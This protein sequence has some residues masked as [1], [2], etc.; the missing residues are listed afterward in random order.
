MQRRLKHICAVA[1]A[2]IGILTGGGN[3]QT[4]SRG[5]RL[6]TADDSNTQFGRAS[7]LR[8]RER[9]QSSGRRLAGE[10]SAALRAAAIRRKLRMRIARSQTAAASAGGWISLGPMPLPSDASGTGLQDYNLVSGRV[11]S[12]AIDPNDPSGNTVFVGAAYGGVWKST[13]AGAA[14]Q[15]PASVNWVPLTDDQETLAIGSI[16]VQPQVANPN[17]ANSVVLAGT[18]ETDSSSDSY[19]GLGILRSID[20]GQ[21]WAL[22]PQDST[23]AHSFAGLGFS[24]IAFSTTNPSLVVAAAAAASR[25]ILEGR[26]NPVGVNR[27]LY[28]SNDAGET[29]Q[30]ASVSDAGTVI[31]PDSATAVVYNTAAATFYSA[32][33][34]HG[35]YSSPDGVN[36]SR[37]AS[38]PGS[39]LQA[40]ACPAVANEPSSCPIYR[41]EIAIVP[42]RTGPSGLGEMYVWYVDANDTD[43]GIWTSQD[44]GATWTPIGE[45]GITNCGDV[46]GGCGTENGSSNLAIA[47]VPDGA[48]T[49]LYAGAVNIY[50]CEITSASPAC[51]GGGANWFLNLTHAYGC[52]AIAKVHPGQHAI[53]FNVANGSSLLYFANDGGIYRALDGYTGLTTG[54]CGGTNQFDSLNQTL[55]PITQFVSIAESASNANLI[56]G[57]TQD[58]GAPATANSES[59][60]WVNVDAGDNGFTA[61]NAND[62][63]E[64]FVSTPP[65]SISGVNV[66]RCANGANCH[67]L[68]FENDEVVSSTTLDGDTGG[69]FAPFLLDPQNASVLIVGTCR[70][71]RGASSGGSF[72]L[73]SPDFETGG[74]GSCTGQE[75][76]LARAIAAGGNKDE[77]S[78]SQVIYAGTDGYGPLIAT[79]PTG[80]QVWVTTN[81]DGGPLTWTNVTQSIN[82]MGFPISSIALDPAD[83]LGK[84]AYVGI[85]GFHTSH[86]WKTTDAGASWNDFSAN[87]LPDVPVNAIVVDSGSSL[88]NGMVYAGTDVGVFATSTG[89]PSWTELNPTSGNVGNLPE[90]AVTS[91]QI[92]NAGGVKRLRAATYGR[93]IWEWNLVTTPDFEI[94]FEASTQTIF[95]S[96]SF[97]GAI[98]A[99]NGYG[100]YVT[101]TCIAGATNPPQNCSVT[102]QPILPTASGASFTVAAGSAI[103]DYQFAVQG[104]GSDSRA[105][106]HQSPI[107]LH[108]VDFSLGTPSASRLNVSPA[109][110]SAAISFQISALGSFSGSVAL[111]CTNLPAGA[112]CQFQPST[113]SPTAGSPVGVTLSVAASSITALGTY[114]IAISA[115]TTGEAAKTQN[116]TLVVASFPDYRLSI[117]NPMLTAPINTSATFN[118]SL[119]AIDGY[120]SPVALSCGAGAPPSCIVSPASVTPSS[121]GAAFTVTVSSAVGQTYQFNIVGVGSDSGSTT[122]AA[123]VSFT[124]TGQGFDFSIGVSPASAS[125]Q[126]GQSPSFTVTVVSSTG[127]IPQNISL[128]CSGLPNLSSCAFSPNGLGPGTGNA[129]T[130]TI[131]TTGPSTSNSGTLPG[132]EPGTYTITVTA[133]SGPLTQTAQLTLTVMGASQAF[134]FNLGV[135]PASASVAAGQTVTL[136]VTLA[137]ATGSFPANVSLSCSN[138]P[139]LATCSFAPLQVSSDQGSA[140]GTFSISTTAPVAAS[141]LGFSPLV[142]APLIALA[143]ATRRKMKRT[144]PRLLLFAAVGLSA[145]G[146]SCGGGLQ[147][148]GGAGGTGSPG[149][150]PG[151]YSVTISATCSSVTHTAPVTL[152]V[153]Q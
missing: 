124:S 53:S 147:G 121:Q 87:T 151:T 70:V 96:Q 113:A 132:T 145:W 9:W 62:D 31:S 123:S 77:N 112:T 6:A 100:S 12:V 43:Q 106:T 99:L 104:V 141:A 13:N 19:Y 48:G 149:T 63:N 126:A 55:G 37:L 26:E 129:S 24:Q 17:P 109:G 82:P 10:N 16:A 81:A 144:L 52:S 3:S 15:N 1:A 20:G 49:D 45:S 140:T 94:S 27:G 23:G 4:A 47:A 14:S 125:V 130:L 56:F 107:T 116:L 11:T 67:T 131:N 54:T 85:M 92:F 75:T 18:G 135:N 35:I 83:P 127:S 40:A 146:V 44:G 136:T 128:S 46:F 60:P 32:I 22:I 152:T 25:G 41:G 122:H 142:S 28:Y 78:N 150:P 5:E 42:S 68:D 108:V 29:W 69:F 143:C 61:I 80:G 73:L 57:G 148:N 111:S 59:G 33:R 134:D 58:N 71:W 74:S 86:V 50:K 97:N 21:S 115:S 102:P 79:T 93:G 91:L 137:S 30:M 38:Q 65:D 110:T 51:N 8:A 2:V 118:G 36:W 133:T 84:T 119:T 139:P 66:F 103:G 64:W 120:N 7:Q 34:F 153:S 88:T 95:P 39:G 76:N 72:T 98:T 138:L 101:L 114:G 89:A 117:A 90:S 105:I